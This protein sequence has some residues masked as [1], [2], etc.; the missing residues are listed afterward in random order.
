MTTDQP[1]SPTA[2][3]TDAPADAPAD[4]TITSIQ[5]VDGRNIQVPATLAPTAWLQL[6]Q[7][8]A[9]THGP[10]QALQLQR[11]YLNAL[12]V[13]TANG[14]KSVVPLSGAED[15]SAQEAEGGGM[16]LTLS[17]LIFIIFRLYYYSFFFLFF[18]II[19]S[20]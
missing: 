12:S 7:S 8:H 13:L 18:L 20:Y 4:V 5:L 15:D 1:Q 10:E 14:T 19:L 3:I 11:Y 16:S 6:L 9:V 17:I 2:T